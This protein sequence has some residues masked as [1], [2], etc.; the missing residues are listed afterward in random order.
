MGLPPLPR[1]AARSSTWGD[2]LP[3]RPQAVVVLDRSTFLSESLIQAIWAG[4][5]RGWQ[6]LGKMELVAEESVFLCTGCFDHAPAR[7]HTYETTAW[8]FARLSLLASRRC[9]VGDGD[10]AAFVRG[11]ASVAVEW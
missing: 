9:A 2:R 1:S 10:V 7:D 3:H 4:C 5:R 11:R 6:Q 8:P